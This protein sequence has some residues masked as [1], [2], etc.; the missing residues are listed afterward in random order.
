[1]SYEGVFDFYRDR[2]NAC[3]LYGF[4]S[5]HEILKAILQCARQDS[6]LTSD[7]FNSII[8]MAEQCHIKMMEDNYNDGWTQNT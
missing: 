1:M 7:E 5:G 6:M 2:I 8:N 4:K 3:P